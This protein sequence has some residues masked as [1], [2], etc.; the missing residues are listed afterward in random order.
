LIVDVRGLIIGVL[1][2]RFLSQ[3]SAIG[4]SQVTYEG[5]EP[6]TLDPYEIGWY[7]ESSD[8]EI[9]GPVSRKTLGQF[10]EEGTISPNTLVRHCTQPEAVP[11]ADQPALAEQLATVARGGAVGDKLEEAWP[12]RNRDRL[13][14]AQ[15]GLPCAW[16]N[17][18][19]ILVCVRCHA[20][21]CRSCQA[22]PY[23]KQFF[24]CRRCQTRV[25]NKRFLAWFLDTVVLY[26]LALGAGIVIGL[27]GVAEGQRGLLVYGILN[28]VF[29]LLFFGRDS[30]FGG[31]GI[32][33][34]A[35][36]LKVVKS[37]DGRTPLNYGQGVIRWLSVL[38]PFFNLIDLSVP[39]RDPLLRRFGDRWAGTRVID[40]DER[41]ADVRR[42]IA[43]RLFRKK[44]V[45]LPQ[46][47]GM[48]ME[49]LAR[50]S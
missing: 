43:G 18:P 15:D 22:K 2:D 42:K 27:L 35:V 29:A 3:W 31:A 6:I 1:F 28:I 14:L 49:E 37:R 46:D 13:A 30:F 19:A 11:V 7:I 32:G 16:H 48:S 34:R 47:F 8:D 36:A 17:R 44:K 9:Y 21:Y 50:L 5:L 45:Q 26:I 33:K 12:R 10:L 40:T 24:L 20:P 25:Y 38:I 41:V 23:R 39:Y 4:M